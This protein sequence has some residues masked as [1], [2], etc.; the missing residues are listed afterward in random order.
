ILKYTLPYANDYKG[1]I[2]N[3]LDS[4]FDISLSIG[5]ISASWQGN[6]PALV[7]EELSFKDN[8]T[9]PISLTI[10]KTSLELNLWESLKS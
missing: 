2:E 1:E 7:L 8:Q 4:K 5:A 9:A 6:G 3:Y 10:A